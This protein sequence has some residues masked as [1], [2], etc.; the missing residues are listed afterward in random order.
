[1]NCKSQKRLVSNEYYR[2]NNAINLRNI[3][4]FAGLLLLALFGGLC[5]VMDPHFSSKIIPC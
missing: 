3:I 1:M 2:N 4:S 5:N